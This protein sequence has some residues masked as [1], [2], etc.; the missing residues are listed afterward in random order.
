MMGRD[1]L[2]FGTVT[3]ISFTMLCSQMQNPICQEISVFPPLTIGLA[4]FGSL[5]PDIDKPNT[6]MGHLFYYFST[7][8]NQFIGHR[9]YTHDL[10]IAG[11]LSIVTLIKC[12]ILFGLWFGY[13]GHLYLDGL[14]VNGIRFAYLIHKNPIYF[15]PRKFRVRTTKTEAMLTTLF[16]TAMVSVL[17]CY[18]VREYIALMIL[19]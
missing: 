10:L 2:L 3:S 11:I 19:M 17:L 5:L 12:P 9:T 8:L 16:A 4:M 15:A 1:H 18:P 13:L 6:L 14:T 7:V